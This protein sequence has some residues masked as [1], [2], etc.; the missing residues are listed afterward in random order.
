[1]T[2]FMDDPSAFISLL[3]LIL[4]GKRVLT[5]MQHKF[6][7]NEKSRKKES[8]GGRHKVY[9]PTLEEMNANVE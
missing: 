1:M 7:W 2:L 4:C 5:F 3:L 6:L 8:K 9:W